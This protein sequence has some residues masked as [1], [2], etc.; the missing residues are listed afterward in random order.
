MLGY[1]CNGGV[2]IDNY[3]RAGL[4][5][6]TEMKK[7]RYRWME[8]YGGWRLMYPLRRSDMPTIRGPWP[9]WLNCPHEWSYA[10]NEE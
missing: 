5:E 6:D 7:P 8:G 9:L 4:L 3:H 2:G 1:R 10:N